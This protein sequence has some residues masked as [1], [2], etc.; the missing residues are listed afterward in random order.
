MPIASGANN[1]PKTYWSRAPKRAGV[2][3]NVIVVNRPDS[4]DVKGPS[5]PSAGSP[6]VTYRSP[7][8]PYRPQLRDRTPSP[9]PPRSP[10]RFEP[11]P[12]GGPRTRIVRYGRDRRYGEP[13]GP[14][15]DGY[16]YGYRPSAPRDSRCCGNHLFNSGKAGGDTGCCQGGLFSN[17]VVDT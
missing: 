14:G 13:S 7:S 3:S 10:R 15:Y 17:K 5:G 16:L 6:H 12:P 4:P 1:W 8:P 9:P 11:P 2:H